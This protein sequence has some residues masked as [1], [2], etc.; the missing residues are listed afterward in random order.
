MKMKVFFF[1]FFLSPFALVMG[2]I[3]LSNILTDN[4]VLQRNSEVT[5]WGTAPAGC[6]LTITVGWNKTKTNITAD[7]EGRWETK[8]ATTEAG[9]P[10]AVTVSSSKEK[11]TLQ[12]ILLGE[13]WLCSGQSNMDMPIRGYSDQ[14]ISGAN[15]ALTEAAN[16]NIR[17]FTLQYTGSVVP[18][19]T[20]KGKY[21]AWKVASAESVSEFSAVAYY[22]AK[23][24]Q[25]KLGI[26][27]GVITTAWGGSRIESWMPQEVITRFPN[28]LQQT[29]DEKLSPQYK[30]SQLYNGMIAPIRKS[31]FKGAIWFQ[32]EANVSNAHEYAALQAAMVDS[33]RK[34]F[35]Q[36]DF[37]FYYVQITPYF[38]GDSKARNA[39][40]LREAQVNAQGLI[41]HS[42]MV[43]TIDL[44]EERG[45]HAPDKLTIARRLSY[46]AF[47]QTYG[48]KGIHCQSPT[49]KSMSVKDQ[50]VTIEFNHVLNGLYSFGKKVE[51]FEIAG[52]DRI[53]YPAN[54]WTN[55]KNQ[56]MLS[57]SK[58]KNPVAVRYGF[59]NYAQTEGFLYNTA[60]L[61]VPAFRSDQW[62]ITSGDQVNDF[63]TPLHLL[64][65][66]YQFSYG[67]PSSATIKS[68]LD[69]VLS[70]LEKV[71][72]PRVINASTNELIT[73]FTQ[74]D[75]NA[76]LGKGQFRLGSYEWGV[77]Y[78]GMLLA[79]QVTSDSRYTH[80]VADRF[81][82]LSEVAPYF[83]RI[84]DAG[85]E[86][87][88]MRQILH[89]RA[90]DDAGAMC[91][92]MIKAQM[93]GI[94]F[95]GRPLIDN[96]MD[97]I[98]K[99]QHRLKDG[100]LARNHPHKNSVW[101]DDMYMSIPAIVNMGK[102]TGDTKYYDEAIRQMKLFASRLF[103]KE[104]GIYRHAWVEGM[105]EHPSFHWGRANGWAILTKIEMLDV[106]PENYPGRK[107]VLEQLRAHVR[108][109]ATLQSSQGLWHQLLNKNDSYLETSCTALFTYCIAKAV[110]KGWIDSL[111]Y[112][113]VAVL[114]W[115]GLS[116]KVN[117][118]G[119]VEGTCV[120]TGMAF[121]PAF[122]YHRPVNKNAAHGYGPVLLAGA[123][124]IRLLQTWHPKV[125][126]N[127][128]QFY[129]YRIETDEPIFGEE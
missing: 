91:A 55:R 44:G 76:Q 33:W 24:L 19:D 83:R 117:A 38:Y 3:R 41:P 9:G 18:Q 116:T 63:N 2:Q 53:F 99:R 74:I 82:F 29:S 49:Y 96:Y 103:V 43:C 109:L 12:N 6:K 68:T 111:A 97:Y 48:F 14:P 5:L 128:V 102:L 1:V 80:Y 88:Q 94:T 31:V 20:L 51:G 129:R 101:I 114:G 113:P 78:S 122:Y 126:D 23:L 45:I 100:I 87:A 54:M 59:F 57:S 79:G 36:G 42:G 98:M 21:G 26:P 107:E 8:V 52:E 119:E 50:V 28:A 112:G 58:V 61:P 35:G 73:D 77:T 37:P 65:P 13:V 27:V 66:D 75:K 4:M 90:L 15:D 120:G 67:V 7:K 86:D 69:R 125:N 11:K 95:E 16:D 39:A 70:F 106:L 92:A 118:A 32:G 60:G 89:P 56:L 72:V 104:L 123:E 84:S 40:L 110:N 105:T 71:T 25:Q 115:N 62:E 81:R 10:Y 17:L 30:A 64:K 85:I 34:E 47:A 127:A 124:M 46:W 108:G 121:D 93:S 22:Y